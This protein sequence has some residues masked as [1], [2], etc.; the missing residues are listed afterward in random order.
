[1]ISNKPRLHTQKNISYNKKAESVKK[2]QRLK[3]DK[4]GDC[5]LFMSDV[6]VLYKSSV[7]HLAKLTTLFAEFEWF[8]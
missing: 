7:A 6:F 4:D 8:D 2:I 3:K 5:V 1:M